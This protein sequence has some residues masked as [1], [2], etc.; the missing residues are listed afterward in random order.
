MSKISSGKTK[1][2][3]LLVCKVLPSAIQIVWKVSPALF[4]L[5]IL[6]SILNGLIPVASIR[7]EMGLLNAIISAVKARGANGQT[8]MVY[9]WLSLQLLVLIAVMLLERGNSFLTFIMGKRLSMD[10]NHKILVKASSLDMAAFETPEFNDNMTRARNECRGKPVHMLLKLNSIVS[11]CITFFVMGLLVYSL[12]MALF[13]MLIVVCVPLLVVLIKYGEKQ[14]QLQYIRTEKLRESNYLSAIMTVK[15]Y[16]PEIMSLSLWCHLIR[17]YL[18]FSR[19]FISQDTELMRR[20]TMVESAAN[21]VMAIGKIGA[22]GYIFHLG[23]GV[24]SLSVGEIMM[25]T[26]AFAH[27]LNNLQESVENISWMYE[28]GLFL[29]NFLELQKV[30]PHMKIRNNGKDIP[31]NIVSVELRNV[32]FRYPGTRR[33]VLEDVNITFRRSESVLLIGSNGSGKTTLI[34]LLMR[35]YDPDEGKILINGVDLREFN[36]NSLRQKIGI[37]FQDYARF[38]LSAREN[39]GFGC[40]TDLDNQDRIRLAAKRAKAYEFLE[41]LPHKF[42]TILTRLFT[43][44]YELSP[45]QW[46][47]VCLA[48]LFMKDTPIY[49]FDEPTASLDIETEAHLIQE[50][51][52]L[53]KDRV[54]I[55]ISHR[56]SRPSISSADKIVVLSDGSILEDGTHE[57]LLLKNGEYARLWSIYNQQ[58][59][60]HISHA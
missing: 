5:L 20:R 10:M 3:L 17:K 12:S 6:T 45:G 15:H 26:R 57:T 22:A 58:L 38:A 41:R 1:Y 11:G 13:T 49:V 53:S 18:H 2:K 55:L 24:L 19:L 40:I 46:Q 35:L 4:I 52:R 42:D 44:G 33:N 60:K 8:A 34:K 39:I 51:V 28:D 7:I 27:A 16:I 30:Q 21:V 9:R 23:T 37:I 32:T 54:C 25:Y 43:N 47:R 59:V 36:I 29:N 14:H 48:R 50:I 56:L 31:T